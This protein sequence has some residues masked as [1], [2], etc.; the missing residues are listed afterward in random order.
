MQNAELWTPIGHS[1]FRIHNSALFQQFSE[2]CCEL[3]T[4]QAFGHHRAVLVEEEVGRD[5]INHVGFAGFVF[6]VAHL[7]PGQLVFLDSF[8]PFGFILVNADADDIETELMEL[9][10]IS[11]HN[12]VLVTA[13]T[14]P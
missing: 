5:V 8:Q 10:V 2:F 12:G 9:L 13:G 1:A 4:S 14:A 3:L 6:A 7:R 11:F